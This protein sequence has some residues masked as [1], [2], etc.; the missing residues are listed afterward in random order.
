MM[1]IAHC[2]FKYKIT[3]IPAIKE[4]VTHGVIIRVNTKGIKLKTE[5]FHQSYNEN[6]HGRPQRDIDILT[7]SIFCSS[8]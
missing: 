1:K 2:P 7:I 8:S 6:K 4:I 5:R 3:L